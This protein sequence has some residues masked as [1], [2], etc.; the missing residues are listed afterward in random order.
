MGYTL[1]TSGKGC[2][3]RHHRTS[4]RYYYYVSKI[5][6]SSLFSISE[7][8]SIYTMNVATLHSTVLLRS[9]AREPYGLCLTGGCVFYSNEMLI[10]EGFG[11]TSLDIA[12]AQRQQGPLWVLLEYGAAEI[13]CW[14]SI[15]DKS[16]LWHGD[17]LLDWVFT[18]ASL[19]HEPEPIISTREQLI[20]ESLPLK[21][22]R[23]QRMPL[24]GNGS[25]E[26]RRI[27]TFLA[28]EERRALIPHSGRI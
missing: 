8:M 15:V 10:R 4:L 9:T 17:V 27:E 14:K 5:L 3:E 19:E 28:G 23:L 2:G 16:L 7:P 13:K 1:T 26:I 25:R 24:K 12:V 6:S 18:S 22:L 21:T 20:V 11:R